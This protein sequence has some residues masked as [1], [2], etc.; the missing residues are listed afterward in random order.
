MINFDKRRVVFS[1]H[2]KKRL[3]ERLNRKFTRYEIKSL[4]EESKVL[5]ETNTHLYL[6][7]D[8]FDLRFPCLKEEQSLIVKSVLVSGMWMDAKN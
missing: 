8:Y 1:R 3:E 6:Y 2:L 5:L 7:H 4:F